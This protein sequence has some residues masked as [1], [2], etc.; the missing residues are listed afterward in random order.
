MQV[1]DYQLKLELLKKSNSNL[2][3]KCAELNDQN[4]EYKME[5][6]NLKFEN[7][8]LLNDFQTKTDVD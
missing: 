1:D 3:D 5:L 4:V 2:T 8:K 6:E 7:Q